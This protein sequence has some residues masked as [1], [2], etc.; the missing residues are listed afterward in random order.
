MKIK[1]IE[2]VKPDDI[3]LIEDDNDRNHSIVTVFAVYPDGLV[4]KEFGDRIY[5]PSNDKE[6]VVIGN[7]KYKQQISLLNRTM[8]RR[9]SKL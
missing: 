4:I 7:T 8:D 2:N 9:I 1:Y 5:V 6:I 3:I